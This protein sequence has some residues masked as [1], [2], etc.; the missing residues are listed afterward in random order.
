MDTVFDN[1]RGHLKTIPKNKLY[2][3]V[4]LL[5]GGIGAAVI[6]LSFIEREEYQ[7]LFIGLTTEDAS[8]VVSRLKEQKIPYKLGASGTTVSVPKE[9][10]SDVRLVLASQNAL[11]G[12]G[13]VGLELFDKTNYGMTEFMQTV[14]YKRAI[15]GELT[16][17]INQMPEVKASRIHIA[18]PEK[19]LFTER[20]K[21]VTASVFLKLKPGREL[22]REQVAAVV[23]L[24]A[25]SIEGLKADN[26]VVI[27]SSGKVLHKSG[28]GDSG[29][30]VS[31][32]QYELQKSVEK[33]IEDS[34]ASML[35]TGADEQQVDRPGERRSQPPQSRED[36]GGVR[37]RQKSCDAGKEDERK[38]SQRQAQGRRGAGGSGKSRGCGCK[39]AERP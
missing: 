12:G 13:G 14:N 16:R 29:L 28:E 24:V 26:V 11:P 23:Q 7:P 36:G 37:P 8:N 25:G 20:E 17:T 35:Q 2:L 3:Y 4:M 38:I 27:D 39:D 10:L 33:K 6:G 18:I 31:G 1:I 19:S 32:Q 5:L 21:E 15:Q 9:K 22:S 34:V 30:A